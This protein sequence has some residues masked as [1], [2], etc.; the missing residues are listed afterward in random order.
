M[1][2]SL[3]CKVALRNTGSPWEKAEQFTTRVYCRTWVWWGWPGWFASSTRNYSDDDDDADGAGLARV[4]VP[5]GSAC[6]S[7]FSEPHTA[8]NLDGNPENTEASLHPSCYAGL[9]KSSWFENCVIKWLLRMSFCEY[10]VDRL[11]DDRLWHQGSWWFIS[12]RWSWENNFQD[13]WP[14][15][16]LP[17]TL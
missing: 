14:P 8:T 12:K 6:F 3:Q 4:W 13:L 17:S 16:A 2:R 1:N 9:W 15:P 10:Y 5:A 7:V 11:I